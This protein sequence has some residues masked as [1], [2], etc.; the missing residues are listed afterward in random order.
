MAYTTKKSSDEAAEQ[1]PSKAR[2][3]FTDNRQ[4]SRQYTQ[5]QSLMRA[6]PLHHHAN[7]IAQLY[8]DN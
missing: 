8:G 2:A 1:T 6:S 5:L 3:S 7:R 4:L